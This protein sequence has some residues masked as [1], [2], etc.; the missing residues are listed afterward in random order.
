MSKASIEFLVPPD[1][2]IRSAEMIGQGIIETDHGVRLAGARVLWAD[3]GAIRRDICEECVSPLRRDEALLA[4]CAYISETQVEARQIGD[5]D[6]HV[7]R[8]TKISLLRPFRYNRAGLA[9]IDPEKKSTRLP[10]YIDIKGCGARPGAPPERHFHKNG[11]LF[12]HDAMRELI[13]QTVI[14]RLLRRLNVR[15][16]TVPV[17]ALVWTGFLGNH[18]DLGSLPTALLVRCAYSRLSRGV[19]MY[20]RG[21]SPGR[22]ALEIELLLRGY[23]I[24]SSNSVTRFQLDRTDNEYQWSYASFQGSCARTDAMDKFVDSVI[25]NVPYDAL[26]V[27]V[28]LTNHTEVDPTTA[29]LVDFGQYGI[30]ETLTL[31]TI[32]QAPGRHIELGDV[33]PILDR[34]FQIGAIIPPQK[35]GPH[36]CRRTRQPAASIQKHGLDIY[37]FTVSQMEA[38]SPLRRACILLAKRLANGEISQESLGTILSDLADDILAPAMAHLRH[39]RYEPSPRAFFA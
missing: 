10:L 2:P 39:R 33:I 16:F 36:R 35:V 5:L 38:Y 3:W 21:T 17:Y 27:N 13:L 15:I 9:A 1:A 19:Q 4:C 23:G 37:D 24:T 14:E 7:D 11:L 34:R 20:S 32:S 6:D 8:A 12:L 25:G 30:Y 28:Q 26:T 29:T 18:D 31:P 22:A